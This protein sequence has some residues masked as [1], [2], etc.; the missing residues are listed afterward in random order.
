MKGVPIRLEFGPRDLDNE[1]CV[2]V[3]RDTRE[4]EVC[5]LADA[6]ARVQELL[7]EIQQN[8]FNQAK[9]IRDTSTITVMEW[10]DFVPALEADVIK[11]FLHL[12]FFCDVGCGVAERGGNA[13]GGGREES[14][15]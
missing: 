15:G 14:G 9:A 7:V 5:K 1:T 12:G 13:R 11:I 6:N 10:K 2:L 3:R 8:M 4:K